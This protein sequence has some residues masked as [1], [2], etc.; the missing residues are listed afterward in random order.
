VAETARSQRKGGSSCRSLVTLSLVLASALSEAAPVGECFGRQRVDC[1]IRQHNHDQPEY[2]PCNHRLVVVFDCGN[3]A[4]RFNNGAGATLNRVAVGAPTSVIDGL[5][6]SSGSVY[7]INSAGV[8]IGRNGEVRVGG[9]FVASTQDLSN[10]NFMAGGA[11]SFSGNSEASVTNLGK[12]G[13]S[14]GDVILI[15]AQVANQGEIQAANGR[16]GL[17]GAIRCW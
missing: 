2:R 12:I 7:L 17:L 16:V 10:N 6:A 11:L 13:A 5:L 1:R 8:I 3:E 15:A 4:V 14:G 9:S